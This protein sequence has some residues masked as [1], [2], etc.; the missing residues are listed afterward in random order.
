MSYRVRR[1]ACTLSPTHLSVRLAV[2]RPQLTWWISQMPCIMCGGRKVKVGVEQVRRMTRQRVKYVEAQ[3]QNWTTANLA[4]EI[5]KHVQKYHSYQPPS[6]LNP[7][8]VGCHYDMA[9]DGELLV[10]PGPAGRV[11]RRWK[12]G[13]KF[14]DWCANRI[15]SELNDRR[16]CCTP[17]S[18]SG[19]AKLQPFKEK[20]LEPKMHS[21]VKSTANSVGFKVSMCLSQFIKL[22]G[23]STG[24]TL[25]GY[26]SAKE[27]AGY[28][29]AA[30][31]PKAPHYATPC[32]P[33][34]PGVSMKG[35]LDSEQRAA[36]ECKAASGSRSST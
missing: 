33:P 17:V 19:T 18:L 10:R 4:V 7:R 8:G 32:P 24:V 9:S 34:V 3:R 26:S 30:T 13:M 21:A 28:D 22:D 31:P 20:C 6:A 14:P 35:R 12:N 25:N 1:T 15:Q 29:N 27:C 23:H 11:L 2:S 5:K 16:Q 36:S